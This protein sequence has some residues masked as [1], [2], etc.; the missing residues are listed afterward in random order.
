MAKK[1]IPT[2]EEIKAKVAD[3]EATREAEAKEKLIR[4]LQDKSLKAIFHLAIGLES[5]DYLK[6]TDNYSK[7]LKLHGNR[8]LAAL[9]KHIAP[10]IDA[11]YVDSPE[12][13]TNLLQ[14]IEGVGDAW[15]EVL[16]SDYPVINQ[17]KDDFLK[18]PEHYRSTVK[19]QFNRLDADI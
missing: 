6:V 5:M 11:L 3:I 9:E 1:K 19:M 17:M 10:K 4:T 16:F 13:T 8:F 18:D 14:Q 7:E 15:S 2:H 12:F